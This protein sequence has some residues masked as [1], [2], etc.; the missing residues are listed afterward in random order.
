MKKKLMAL[1]FSTSLVLAACGG[2]GETTEEEPAGNTTPEQSEE[3]GGGDTGS[4]GGGEEAADQQSEV[5]VEEVI[6]QNCTSCHGQNLE[7]QGNFPAIND[8]GSRLSEE[9]IR[10]VIDEGQGAMPPDIIDGE[11]ADAVAAWLAQQQ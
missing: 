3:T 5:N 10:T 11:E 9:E 8:V 7:G 1:F 2:G 4:S 6:Q